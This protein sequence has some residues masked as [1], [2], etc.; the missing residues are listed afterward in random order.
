MG[1]W[2]PPSDDTSNGGPSIG[3]PWDF[4][5]TYDNPTPDTRAPHSAVQDWTISAQS[6][7]AYVVELPRYPL[8]AD[9]LDHINASSRHSTL[10]PPTM[11]MWRSSPLSEDPFT[12][13][14][15]DSFSQTPPPH[16]HGH[17]KRKLRHERRDL[18]QEL[19]RQKKAKKG[20]KQ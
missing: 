17:S 12:P 13:R 16:A 14:R 18:G 8:S 5:G 9:R 19:A 7:D 6:Q 4:P 2:L 3:Y 11:E 20:K 1:A 10:T 15:E